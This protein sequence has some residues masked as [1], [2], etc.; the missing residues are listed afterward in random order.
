MPSPAASEILS[1]AERR[2]ADVIVAR[3]SCAPDELARRVLAPE[4]Q[5]EDEGKWIPAAARAHAIAPVFDPGHPNII[6]IDTTAL[7][8]ADRVADIVVMEAAGE[9][10]R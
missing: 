3:L 4:R 7:R 8:A 6:D 9:L 2:A 10:W 1:A 5:S